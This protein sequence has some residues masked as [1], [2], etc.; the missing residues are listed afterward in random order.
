M[1]LDELPAPAGLADVS[2]NN[3]GTGHNLSGVALTIDL[4]L[5]S[6]LAQRFVALD[7]Q[8]KIWRCTC[9]LQPE[10]AENWIDTR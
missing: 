6:Q 7:L 1:L 5:A 4:A 8:E 10:L 2:H 3:A 9:W